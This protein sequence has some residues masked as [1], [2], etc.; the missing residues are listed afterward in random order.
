MGSPVCRCAR[1]RSPVRRARR[2][3]SV[4]AA[5]RW[6]TLQPRSVSRVPGERFLDGER[7]AVEVAQIITAYLR[8]TRGLRSQH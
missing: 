3:K 5:C 7:V 6:L 1:N 2:T 8:L 4:F